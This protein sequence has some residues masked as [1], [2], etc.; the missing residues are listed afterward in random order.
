MKLADTVDVLVVKRGSL[1]GT[2]KSDDV[3]PDSDSW[4]L[5]KCPE[6]RALVMF[7]DL[8]DHRRKEDA[9]QTT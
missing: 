8:E 5:K 7:A 6:C 9:Q 3:Y 4:V 1:W 2:D